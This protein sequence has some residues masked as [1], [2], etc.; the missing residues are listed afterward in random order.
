MVLIREYLRDWKKFLL[1]KVVQYA[2]LNEHQK[3]YETREDAVTMTV[4]N[5]YRGTEVNDFLRCRKKYDYT[6][7]QNLEPKKRNEKL[8]IG[9]A[10]HK[11]LEFWYLEH[12]L[13]DAV[14]A[15]LV[16]IDDNTADMDDAERIELKELAEG[17]CRHYVDHYH[18]EWEYTVK[19]VEL[20]FSIP[21]VIQ[22]GDKEIHTNYTGTIDLLVEDTDGKLWFMDHKTTASLDI[23]DKNSDMDRQISRY[24]YAL[25]KLGYKIEGF[26]YNII[27]KDVPVEPR[28]LKSGQLSKDRSQKTTAILYRQAIEKHGLD[29][30]DYMDHMQFLYETP[31]E[32][33]RRVK[34]TRTPEERE[35][36]IRETREVILDITE[37][38][39]YYRNI[40]KDCSWDCPF[41]TLCVSEMDGSNADLIRNELYQ[42]KEDAE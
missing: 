2:T 13:E 12:R 21:Q 16:Y 40:T 25:E 37:A 3:E 15:M 6:W 30:N 19:A 36:S 41:K 35:A 4:K 24:W 9:S 34:V 1:Y 31:K 42:V 8:T 39:R 10:I 5:G 23:Y 28:L 32:F 7:V 29:L 20:P 18:L 17:V 22:D 33:F 11:F 38:K 26:I 27:L 14:E